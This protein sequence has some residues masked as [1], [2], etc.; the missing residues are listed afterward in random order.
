MSSPY[1]NTLNHGRF[2]VHTK[3]P[4]ID[5][6]HA[7][8]VHGEKIV[9]PSELPCD[10]DGIVVQWKDLTQPIAIKTADCLPVVIEGEKGVVCLHA[11]WRG[12]KA[13][14][15]KQKEVENI[16][17]ERV[18]IGPSIHVCCFEVTAEFKDYFPLNKNFQ[19][20]EKKLFFDLQQEARDQLRQMFPNLL[21]EVSPICTSC[22][23]DFHSY[24]RDKP[25][26]NERN[27]NL[28]FKG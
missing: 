16:K 19:T 8:Q 2:E 28:Y 7:K 6:W 18:L 21:V 24:R 15:L 14:I 11:G 3:K 9:G 10:A 17:P 25:P 26:L 1:Q 4:E 13:G 12:L 5:F 22:N 20:R 27:W 23:K